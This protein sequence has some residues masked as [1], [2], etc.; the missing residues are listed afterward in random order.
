MA[1]GDSSSTAV[2]AAEREADERHEQ[3]QLAEEEEEEEKGMN[4]L[5]PRFSDYDPK[6]REYIITRYNYRSKLDLDQECVFLY[7]LIF[8]VDP[9][10]GYPA[11]FLWILIVDVCY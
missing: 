2:V 1:G 9:C 8:H 6:Q 10:L 4:P 3:P 7:P 11:T 5:D